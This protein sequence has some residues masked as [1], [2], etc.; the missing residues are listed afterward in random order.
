MEI[1]IGAQTDQ[2]YI[3]YISNGVAKTTIG[4]IYFRD[5]GLKSKNN[6]K[7]NLRL[8]NERLSEAE[9]AMQLGP[10]PLPS[11]K[12]WLVYPSGFFTF[13]NL[14]AIAMLSQPCPS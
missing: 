7:H 3:L 10:F 2:S 8:V 9:R 14:I 6:S 5:E 12:Q 11:R 13:V 1:R 4:S